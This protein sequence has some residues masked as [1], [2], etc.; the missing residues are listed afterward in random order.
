MRHPSEFHIKA[1][2]KASREATSGIKSWTR[3]VPTVKAKGSKKKST[4][5]YLMEM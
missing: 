5:Q 4:R 2:K 3:V 1:V